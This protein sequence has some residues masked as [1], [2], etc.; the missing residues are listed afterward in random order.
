MARTQ[1][2]KRISRNSKLR[3]RI[4]PDI[5][6]DD[7]WDWKMENGFATVPRTLPYFGKIMDS[8][9]KGKPLSSTYIALWCRLWDESGIIKNI[10]SSE[11]A[12]ES[13]F[14]GQRAVTTWRMRMKKLADLGFIRIKKFGTEEYGYIVLMHPY[15][16]SKTL[17]KDGEGYDNDLYEM[18]NTRADQIGGLDFEEN[19]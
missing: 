10:N 4:F 3:K 9:S 16:V 19:E 7:I 6:D 12:W 14:S 11:L 15:K 13:G 8:L 1:R 5:K 18:L 17:Y 2:A